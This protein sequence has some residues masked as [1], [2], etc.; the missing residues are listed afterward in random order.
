MR[1]RPIKFS[2]FG[3]AVIL[4]LLYAFSFLYRSDYS[5]DQDLGRHIK[6]GEIIFQNGVP[7]T[8]QFSYTF[9]DFSFINHHYLFEIFVFKGQEIIGL[10]NLL[11][12]K[13]AIILLA[14]FITLKISSSLSSKCF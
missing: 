13:L 9:P 7:R 12:L 14:V 1:F 6:L 8:N 4:L 5:L 2:F 10:Q 3:L 11:I